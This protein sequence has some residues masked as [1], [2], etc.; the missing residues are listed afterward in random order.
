MTNLS[1]FLMLLFA[2]TVT[3]VPVFADDDD[4]ERMKLGSGIPDMVLYITVS[5]IVGTIGYTGFKIITARRPKMVK[6]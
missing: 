3:T 2:I 5:A 6:K 4:D 1:L